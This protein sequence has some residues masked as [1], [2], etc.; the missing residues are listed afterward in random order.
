MDN[1]QMTKYEE[2]V[3]KQVGQKWTDILPTQSGWYYAK[4]DKNEFAQVFLARDKAG[5]LAVVSGTHMFPIDTYTRWCGPW[6]T[7][8]P[9]AP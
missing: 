4:T 1:N 2:E 9:P 3:E 6:I 8:S 7:G 5:S